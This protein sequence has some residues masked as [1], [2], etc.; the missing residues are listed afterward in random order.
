MKNSK[1]TLKK[2][3][4]INEKYLKALT[5]KNAQLYYE[6]CG[7]KTTTLKQT[8]RRFKE[9]E[10]IIFEIKDEEETWV[11]HALD[12]ILGQ[13]KERW[14]NLLDLTNDSLIYLK[15]FELKDLLLEIKGLED[16]PLKEALKEGEILLKPKGKKKLKVFGDL[17]ALMKYPQT[18]FLKKSLSQGRNAKQRNNSK[19]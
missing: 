1:I 15:S 19:K 4:N 8:T 6:L 10:K 11:S 2:K 14:V 9:L 16:I 17:K 5:F 7:F 18:T 13:N 12:D 3:K